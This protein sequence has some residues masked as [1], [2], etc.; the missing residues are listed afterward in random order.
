MGFARQRDNILQL[1]SRLERLPSIPTVYAEIVRLLKDPEV[2][3]TDVGALIVKDMGITAHI[4]KVVN[5]SFFGLPRRIAAPEEAAAYLGIE[6]VKAL[7]LATSVFHQFASTMK[8]G[9][10]VDE[11][12]AHSQRVGAAARRIAQAENAP[13]SVVNESLVAGFLHDTGK[14]VLAANLPKEFLQASI[15]TSE[16]AMDPLEAERRIF[17]SNHADVGG[18][19]LGLWGLPVPV[20]E[21]IALHHEPAESE[22][23]EFSPLTAVH[24]ADALVQNRSHSKSGNHLASVDESYL[25]RLGCAE[26]LP[27]WRA[28]VEESFNTAAI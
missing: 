2:C 7:V 19:L 26:R 16:Q 4:L 1:L 17:G 23:R 27:V 24:V 25:T 13:S 10:S 21:A 3:M 22:C 8:S 11:L 5:S 15:L 28:A 20:V 14:L 18:Y 9:F 6:T 12:S